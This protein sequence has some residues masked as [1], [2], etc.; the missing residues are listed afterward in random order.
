M[1][2]ILQH[3]DSGH[4]EL[5][6]VPSPG[7]TPGSVLIQTSHSLVSLG[8]E[9]MLVEFGKAGWIQKIRQQ[10]ERVKDVLAKISTD[11]LIPTIQAIR[12]K[13]S[14]PIPLGYC[15]VGR[16]IDQGGSTQFAVGDRVVS[17]GSH[18]EVVSAKSYLCAK[19][20]DNVLSADAS[21]TPLAAIA[22]NGIRMM[23]VK[24]GSR[25]V[26][27]GLGLIGQLAVQILRAQ[28][29]EVL[30]IDLNP[31]KCARA[32]KSGAHCLRAEKDFNPVPAILS[33]TGGRG[34]DGVLI[35]AS[36]PSHEIISQ[37]AQSCCHRG[38]IVLIGVIGLNLKRADFYRNEVSLQVSNSYGV[39]QANHPFSAQNNFQSVLE[40]M[41]Q[42]K[43]VVSDLISIQK[44]INEAPEIYSHLK[45]PHLFGISLTYNPR[46]ESLLRKIE[47]K[48]TVEGNGLNVG[49]LG[50]GNFTQRTLLPELMGIENPP[51]LEV[52][53]SAQGA[54]TLFSAKKFNA[55]S[56][57]TDPDAVFKNR[58]IKA[59]FISTRHHLHATQTVTALENGQAVWV[60]KPLALTEMEIDLI[61]KTAK[62]SSAILMVGFNRRF[63]PLALH[64]RKVIAS[65]S[66]PKTITININAGSLPTDHWT[67]NPAEG[68][69]RIVGEACH[70]IDLLRF[71]ISAP[72]TQ[73][74]LIERFT[75]GQDGGRYKLEF[76]DGSTG[77]INYLTNLPKTVPKE[78]ILV[79]GSNWNF[80]INNWQQCRGQGIWGINKGWG[81]FN[82]IN[83]GH[84]HALALF[85]HAVE[86]HQ[87]SP[88]PLNEII[89]VSRWA[90][91]MQ[92]M[93]R[94]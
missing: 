87:S 71:L 83:K 45:N 86:L 64:A 53:V 47:L 43:L 22:L 74:N 14:Q 54:S 20:P 3:L 9:K 79:S 46:A 93:T 15:Q 50:V 24:P 37:A 25:V 78:V 18:A 8:T 84:S 39:R 69:G 77:Y 58:N 42:G 73:V 91:R 33:W 62:T 2:Q 59:V 23:D 17:N 27:S 26:V 40:L 67:L 5:V 29:A 41:S 35:T 66:G 31:D 38:K 1:L 51:N 52:L 80:K 36:S 89:E 85:V 7:P 13:L 88:I 92:A 6:D 90:V 72:I 30:G 19:I 81:L 76:A 28:G 55:A 49:I 32:E 70:F 82:K 34:V 61:E 11:G 94:S 68:G 12:S 60:E 4:T 21:F 44:T 56:V 75:D 65:Q 16:V 48:Q 10:P 57:A 63:A